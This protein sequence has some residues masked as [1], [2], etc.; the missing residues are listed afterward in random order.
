MSDPTAEE[1]A[2]E[3]QRDIIWSRDL[4]DAYET[5]LRCIAPLVKDRERLEDE[6]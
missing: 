3:L 5:I 4:D 6:K 1:I 2:R